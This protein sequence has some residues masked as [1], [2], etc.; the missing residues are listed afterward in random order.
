MP[1]PALLF[2]DKNLS[3]EELDILNKDFDLILVH[4]LKMESDIPTSLTS[5]PLKNDSL[6]ANIKEVEA[7]LDRLVKK[8]DKVTILMDEGQNPLLQASIHYGLMRYHNQVLI[9]Y[10]HEHTDLVSFKLDVE[11]QL[12]HHSQHLVHSGD[13]KGASTLLKGKVE[14]RRVFQ[15]LDFA[16]GLLSLELHYSHPQNRDL[17]FTTLCDVLKEI[18]IEWEEEVHYVQTMKKLERQDQTAFI[19]YLQNYASE[20]YR[21]NDLVDFIV[22]FYRLAE[23]CLLYAMGWDVDDRNN[24]FFIRKNS[25]NYIPLAEVGRHFSQFHKLVERRYTPL[26]KKYNFGYFS[27]NHSIDLIGIPDH[28]LYICKL[29]QNFSQ[30]WL[31][32]LLDLRHEGVSGHGFADFSRELF[33]EICEGS[34]VEK[35]EELLKEWNILAP[36]SIFSIVQK[37]VLALLARELLD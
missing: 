23:E 12:Y 28:D 27:T 21:E 29:Y 9:K 20:L 16:Q 6:E 34:P 22:L 11:E 36:Q 32:K 7:L 8:D 30:S 18:S 26:K 10:S 17:Y 35:M 13:Y 3:K 37:A 2:R 1:Q 15:L 31:L 5:F 4:P 24:Q 19:Y 33:E 14:D 25:V